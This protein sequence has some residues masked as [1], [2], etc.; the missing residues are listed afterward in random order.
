MVQTEF[1]AQ[2]GN[3][4]QEVT[5]FAQAVQIC[6]EQRQEPSKAGMLEQISR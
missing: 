6:L 4:E 3:S 2:A 5:S 1:G